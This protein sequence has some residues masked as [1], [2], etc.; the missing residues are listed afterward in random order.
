MEILLAVPTIES[1]A[2]PSECSGVR[3]H[4]FAEIFFLGF[5]LYQTHETS[6]SEW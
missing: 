4:L 1:S 6:F 3:G 2:H 5:E